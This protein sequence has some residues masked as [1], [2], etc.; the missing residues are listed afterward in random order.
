[1]S[2]SLF[3][4]IVNNQKPI[5]YANGRRIA[6]PRAIYEMVPLNEGDPPMEYPFKVFELPYHIRSRGVIDKAQR[7]LASY[8]VIIEVGVHYD[9]LWTA[10][11]VKI[12]FKQQQAL[13]G[14][15]KYFTERIILNN[16][17]YHMFPQDFVEH[18]AMPQDYWHMQTVKDQVEFYMALF[19]EETCLYFVRKYSKKKRSLYLRQSFSHLVYTLVLQ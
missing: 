5:I 19:H 13:I 7:K 11:G 4:F 14:D 2:S 16:T 18:M 17:I 9:F 12:L 1:M 6:T 10:R 15:D 8:M 3:K